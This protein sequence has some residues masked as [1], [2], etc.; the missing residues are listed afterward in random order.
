MN[1]TH[2]NDTNTNT[3][4]TDNISNKY[5]NDNNTNNSNINDDTACRRASY[6]EAAERAAYTS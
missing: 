3:E 2:D 1:N 5:T 4:L 6:C